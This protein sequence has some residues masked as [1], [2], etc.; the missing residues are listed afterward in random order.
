VLEYG[1]GEAETGNIY[2]IVCVMAR[3]GHKS[4][5]SCFELAARRGGNYQNAPGSNGGRKRERVERWENRKRKI[6][7]GTQAVVSQYKLKHKYR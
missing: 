7:L 5:N 1:E 6:S 4:W 3:K 2:K